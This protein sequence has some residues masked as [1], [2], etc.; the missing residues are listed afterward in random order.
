MNNLKNE[1]KKTKKEINNAKSNHEI[2][3]PENIQLL[4]NI[5]DD[6]YAYTDIDNS[7]TVFKAINEI[8]YLIKENQL[9]VTI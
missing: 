5:V 8:L 6:S 4:S 1:I 3:N 9:F 2:N 7:F